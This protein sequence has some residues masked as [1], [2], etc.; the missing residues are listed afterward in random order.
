MSDSQTYNFDSKLLDKIM[1]FSVGGVFILMF[2]ESGLPRFI[3]NTENK[4]YEL[5]IDKALEV[6]LKQRD[7]SVEQSIMDQLYGQSGPMDDDE[8]DD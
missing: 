2:D 4:A 7:L 1:E 3:R 6:Y 8:G 5:A